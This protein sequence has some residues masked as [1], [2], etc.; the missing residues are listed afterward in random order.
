MS[1][2]DKQAGQT[3]LAWALLTEGVAQARLD[4]HRLR[5]LLSRALKLV[6]NSPAKE[7]L[8]EAAG[9]MITLA[10]RRMDALETA[11]DRTSYALSVL[12]TDH[13]RDR[14]PI[15]DRAIV[16]DATHKARPFAAPQVSDAAERVAS[17]Y[18]RRGGSDD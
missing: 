11:L 4:A 7:H 5:H 3:Q 13:L 14:L 9:D 16:D 18:L 12:G 10:P 2:R 8:Y 15:E 6:E 17:R 1:R